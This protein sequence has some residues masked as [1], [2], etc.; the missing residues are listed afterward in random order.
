MLGKDLL[1]LYD[2]IVRVILPPAETGLPSWCPVL[3]VVF[4]IPATN[5]LGLTLNGMI[6]VGEF[7]IFFEGEASGMTVDS[8]S[9]DF[10]GDFYETVEET[11]SLGW[12]ISKKDGEW[13]HRCPECAR[14]AGK[15][16]TKKAR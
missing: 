8:S 7:Q 16:G 6:P 3:A 15:A 5:L 9:L 12:R 14:S 13:M 10:D 2:R 1:V 11:K 4:L